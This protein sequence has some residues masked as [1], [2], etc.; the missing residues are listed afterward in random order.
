MIE[1]IYP[2][3][4]SSGY[5]QVSLLMIEDDDIDATALKRAFHKLKLL[6]PVYRARDGLEASSYY[7]QDKFQLLTSFY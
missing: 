1:Q 7:A 6:N 5:R 4:P 3:E 2:I